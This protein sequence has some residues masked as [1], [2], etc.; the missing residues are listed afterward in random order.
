MYI[1]LKVWPTVYKDVF[2]FI[3]RYLI[4]LLKSFNQIKHG[5]FNKGIIQIIKSALYVCQQ[6]RGFQGLSKI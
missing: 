3:P 4:Y 5:Y 6:I 1:N 2:Y